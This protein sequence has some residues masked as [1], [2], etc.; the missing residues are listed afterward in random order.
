MAPKWLY[1]T[2]SW[3]PNIRAQ[4]TAP[5]RRSQIVPFRVKVEQLRMK[6]REGW[7]RSYGHVMR[8]DQIYVET[9]VMEMK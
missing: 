8:R 4:E 2:V 5:K 3:R 6:L 9:G 7:L 1:L